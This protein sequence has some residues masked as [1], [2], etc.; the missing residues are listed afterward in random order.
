MAAGDT[1]VVFDPRS[2]TPVASNGAYLAIRNARPVLVFPTGANHLADFAFRMPQHY[3]GSGLDVIVTFVAESV[4]SGDVDWDA[5][6]ERVGTS[7]DVDGDS[8]AAANSTDNT[9]VSGTN[10]VPVEATIAFTDGADMDSLAA[11]EW[12]RLRLTR[13]DASDTVSE[14]VQVL[15]VEIRES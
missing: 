4:T 8:F 12:G 7:L 2:Y 5:Q 1:L 13:D 11:G 9:S 14:G 15:G 6:I 10:G 3:G